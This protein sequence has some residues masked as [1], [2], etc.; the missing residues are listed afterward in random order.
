[1]SLVLAIDYTLLI[2]SRYH[3]K[4]AGGSDR[5]EARIPTVVTSGHTVLFSTVTVAL[6]MSATVAFSM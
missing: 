4:L 6:S 2:V 1:M 3:D 5:G